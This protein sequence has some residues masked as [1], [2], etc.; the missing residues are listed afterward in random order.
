MSPAG[1][2]SELP[3][4]WHQRLPRRELPAQRCAFR[5]ALGFSSIPRSPQPCQAFAWRGG[6]K[7]DPQGARSPAGVNGGGLV[8]SRYPAGGF[9][10]DLHRVHADFAALQS[11]AAPVSFLGGTGLCPTPCT[12]CQGSQLGPCHP[13]GPRGLARGAPNPPGSWAQGVFPISHPVLLG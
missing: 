4:W 11:S 2:E 10:A 5:A 13:V 12:P 3:S 6:A 8:S 9:S 1:K 7:G